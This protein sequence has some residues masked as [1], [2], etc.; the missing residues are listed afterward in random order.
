MGLGVCV[1]CGIRPVSYEDGLCSY[2]KREADRDAGV[3][4][5]EQAPVIGVEFDH[6]QVEGLTSI[7][8]PIYNTDYSLFH[9]TGHCIG[10]VREHT[11]PALTPYEIIIVDNGSPCQPPSPNSYYADKVIKNKEN[12]GVTKAWNQGI[13]ASF[14]EFI[15]L[16][17]NDAQVYDHWL[18]DMLPHLILGEADL[19]MAHP[20]YSL[21][22]PFARAAEARAVREGRKV[23]D[24]LERDFACVAFK[25]SLLDEVGLF[26]EQFFSYAQDSDLFKRMDE[27]GKKYLMLDKVA[28]HH[29][30]G[31]TGHTMAET[32]DVMNR[33]KELYAKKWADK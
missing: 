25:K 7:I 20:M 33:D 23:L 28:I 19:V 32:S 30:I 22:E 9:Y 8:I 24:H 21:T 3:T 11:D 17:N 29:I 2:C 10:S 14:G 26:D 15:V 4:Y 1:K 5:K 18:E 27:K 12:L 31:A 6:K 13:R 16:L